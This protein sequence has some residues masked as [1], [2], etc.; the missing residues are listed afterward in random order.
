MS[1]TT[2]RPTDVEADGPGIIAVPCG[3]SVHTRTAEA[4]YGLQAPARSARMFV[5]AFSTPQTKRNA[6]VVQ[7]L[8]FTAVGWVIFVDSDMIPPPDTLTRLL[9]TG[10]DVVGALY[11]G[12]HRGLDTNSTATP[13]YVPE[14]GPDPYDR[15]FEAREVFDKLLDVGWVGAGALLVRRPVLERIGYPYFP[16]VEIAGSDNED[17]AFCAKARAAGFT[18]WCDGRVRV[19]HIQSVPVTV[20]PT[21]PVTGVAAPPVHQKKLW[22][23]QSKKRDA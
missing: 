11:A 18:V 19:P 14:C 22:W 2:R 21:G 8:R 9:A 15:D 12:R 17:L 23:R 16:S 5:T 6:A 10:K 4:V 7:M 20:G 13:P 1:D 3:A